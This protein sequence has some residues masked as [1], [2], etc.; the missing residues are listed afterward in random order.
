ML[1][2]T[3]ANKHGKLSGTSQAA[4]QVSATAGY[5]WAIVAANTSAIVTPQEIKNRIIYSADFFPHL[6]NK[7]MGG[8]LNMAKA[9]DIES[10]FVKSLDGDV[11]SG[12]LDAYRG[13]DGSP[14]SLVIF[15]HEG[16]RIEIDFGR[17]KRLIRQTSAPGYVVFYESED[18]ELMRKVGVGL[19]TRR[20]KIHVFGDNNADA[21]IELQHIADYMSDF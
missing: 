17:L 1:S 14:A 9:L 6:Q 5:L 20:Q 18:G 4:P 8:R 16:Q 15:R 13:A 12:T 19:L 3:K 10:T 21:Q 7:I 11:V 2:A